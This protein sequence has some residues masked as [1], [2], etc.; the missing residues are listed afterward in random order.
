MSLRIWWVISLVLPLTMEQDRNYESDNSSCIGCILMLF[1]DQLY[2]IHMQHVVARDLW[3]TLYRKYAES[4][5]GRERY[6][7]DQYREYMMVDDRSVVEQNH[8]IQLLVGE[9]AHS[10]FVLPNKFVV[11][12]NIAKLP[13][14][15]RSLT[16]AL[17]HEEAMTIESL[18]DTLDV[19]EKARSKDVPNSC[20][21]DSETSNANLVEGK[22]GGSNKNK[23]WKPKAKQNTDL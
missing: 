4:D 17:K 16:T 6:V 19:E 11:G 1:S 8:G 23:S 5:V 10:N 21:M 9:L 14:T 12:D 3:E 22:S 13:P 7:N 20:P 18:I 2:G 15:W